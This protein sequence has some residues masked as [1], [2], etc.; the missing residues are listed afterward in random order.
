MSDTTSPASHVAEA[1]IS[2][3]DHF[4]KHFKPSGGALTGAGQYHLL[5]EPCVGYASAKGPNDSKVEIFICRNYVPFGYTPVRGSIDYASYLSKAGRIM[6]KKP[7]EVHAFAVM[8]RLG[9]MLDQYAYELTAK[10]EFRPRKD[11]ARWD[12]TDN[13]IAWLGGGLAVRSL[14]KLLEGIKEKEPARAISYSVQLPD[15]A[16]LDEAQDDV[17]RLPFTT[18]V[19]ITGAPG[20]GKTTVL[21]KRLSQKTKKEF[22][23]EAEQKG[24]SDQVFKDGKNWILFTPSDLLKVYLKEA[25]AKEL[26]PATDEHVKVYRTFR[27]EVLRDSGFIK[28]GPHGYFK[29]APA[30]QALMKR[31]TGAEQLNLHKAFTEHLASAYSLFFREAL[32]RF[33]NEIRSPLNGLTDASQKVLTTALDILAKT[34]GD[35]IELRE[36]QRRAADYRKLNTDLNTMVQAVRDIAETLDKVPEISPPAIYNYVGRWQRAASTLTTEEIDTAVFP[37]IPPL[38]AK[39]KKEVKDLVEALSLARLFLLIPRAYQ[40]FREVPTNQTRFFE[41]DSEKALRDRQLSEP[42]QDVL[43]FQALEFTRTLRG[44]LP[45]DQTGVPD[46]LRSL[47]TR[48]RLLVTVDEATDFSPLELACMERF[49]LPEGGVTISGDLMQRVTENGLR[50]WADMNAVCRP[51]QTSEL[52]V[53]YRQTERLF[54]IARDLYR[55]ATGLE[56]KF[57]SAYPARPEDPPALSLKTSKEAPAAL[58]LVDRICEIFTLGGKHLPTTAILVPTLAD[59][60]PLKAALLPP[61]R[62]NG[63]E[64]DAS[65]GGQDLGDSARVRIFPV[66]HIKGLEFEAV[67]YV[68]LDRMADIHKELI[69]KYV[70]VGLSRARSFLGVSFERQFPARLKPIEHHF[71]FG[72]VWGQVPQPA[73]AAQP[74]MDVNKVGI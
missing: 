62:E 58:W 65:H 53:S 25:M 45:A 57:K 5:N 4:Q 6:A 56:P 55:H 69:D 42:E 50:D 35:V 74:E 46:E 14:R 23:T 9:Y 8:D 54:N 48:F 29:Q 16:I 11:G 67:F 18:Y 12:A 30:G 70:Y 13:R 73:R 72:G 66:E 19:L 21:L 40:E 10:D 34:G 43:L 1:I 7:G 39:L 49:A 47:L 36:A 27:L 17:F 22:L 63:L 59:V 3:L 24:L 31:T 33:N 32:Q 60:E 51:Y 61:L 68:G 28:V 64:L 44:Q 52:N 41:L 20:T 37:N 2:E 38:V 26:L 15:Q 71:Q